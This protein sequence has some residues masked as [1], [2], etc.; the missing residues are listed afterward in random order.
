[1]GYDI[2]QGYVQILPSTEK[3]GST[4]KSDLSGSAEDAGREAGNKFAS[5][6]ST[7][8]KVAGAAI[9]AAF[10]GAVKMAGEVVNAYGD[11]EQLVGGVQKLFGEMD[12]QAVVDNA[13]KA[14]QTAGMSSNNYM[15]TVTSFAASLINSL[16]GDTQKA[17]GYAD[18]AVQDMSDNANTFGTSI[19][20]I[21]NAYQGFAKQNYT[22]LDNLKLGYGGTKTEMERLVTDAEN[23]DASFQA[24]RDESGKLT[25]SFSDIVDAIH[26][27]QDNMNI[28]GTTARE[29][30]GTIQGSVETM[31]AAWENLLTGM[32]DPNAN[33]DKL[34]Q[35]F[36]NSFENVINNIEPVI[37]NFA[38][39]LPDVLEAVL[40]AA[41]DVLPDL[42]VNLLPAAVA[43][44][45]KLAA[46]LITHIPD[47][48]GG[49]LKGLVDGIAE[50]IG[51]EKVWDKIFGGTDTFKEYSGMLDDLGTDIDNLV[52]SI[53][54][55]TT[56]FDNASTSALANADSASY[57]KDRLMELIDKED[58]TAADKALIKQLV[59]ELNELVPG[60]AL[61]YDDVTDSLNLT[62]DEMDRYIDNA[63]K[64]AKADAARE[65]LTD[66]LYNQYTAQQ[67][68]NE[69]N[70][71]WLD[72]MDEYSVSGDAFMM[73]S[74]GMA[75]GV[76][77]V[78][79]GLKNATFAQAAF[80][81]EID[82][83]TMTSQQATEALNL[84]VT[85]MQENK[86]A[87][88]A[89]TQ[90]SENAKYAEEELYNATVDLVTETETAVT[91]IADQYSQVFGVEMPADLQTAIQAASDAGYQIPDG[92]VTGLSTGD[93]EIGN[94]VNRMNA[95][96]TFEQ[97][98]SSADLG[99]LDVSQA[100]VNSWL[101]GEYSLTE[102][103][104]YM[105]NLI[106][107]STAIENAKNGGVEVTTEFVNGLLEEYGLQG[108]VSAAEDIGEKAKPTIVANDINE[109]GASVP[110]E[111]ANGENANIGLVEDASQAV[112]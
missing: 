75:E 90:A 95:L 104:A 27:V 108:V 12:Y 13:S 5:G 25:L 105:A 42:I 74:Q 24:T 28:T 1:M 60:L 96:V 70:R 59:Q 32:G 82:A 4:L 61:A 100:F 38:E 86:D 62:N 9:S 53:K 107:F 39:V 52:N 72:L 19:E 48:L 68:V 69:T 84:L 58:K 44:L 40:D 45:A 21:Q 47:I 7:G 106:E 94:A 16:E 29:A 98:V 43:G 56:E 34:T 79:G 35:D 112:Y 97:A 2:A 26:I 41:T 71:A 20:A 76:I 67:K 77:G 89:Y 85:A 64:Q 23:L 6:L 54:N 3:F 63:Y 80:K 14:F 30:A 83:G 93:I 88:D 110:R 17:V 50:A 99:G 36:I 101:S 87:T 46:G 15:E 8:L 57:L 33:I 11:Y 49:I 103:N 81:D 22:M 66:S 37:K 10:A 111:I 102:A 31:K 18:K 78:D 109:V 51:G 91:T 73:I 55:S 92:L 65:Y